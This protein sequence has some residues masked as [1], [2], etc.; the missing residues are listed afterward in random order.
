[1]TKLE[2]KEFLDK[3]D[4]TNAMFAQ[5]VGK[6]KQTVSRWLTGISRVPSYVK[7]YVDTIEPILIETRLLLN[8]LEIKKEKDRK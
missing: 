2:L 7:F 3:Y 8:K 4:I 1:M 5:M 6:N